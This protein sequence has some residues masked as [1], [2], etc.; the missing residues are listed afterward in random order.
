MPCAML[1]RGVQRIGKRVSASMSCHTKKGIFSK[2]RISE[3]IATHAIDD[4]SSK[5]WTRERFVRC[6]EKV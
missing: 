1:A 6:V 3:W 4:C 5:K 2:K